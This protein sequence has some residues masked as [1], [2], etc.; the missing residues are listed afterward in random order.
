MS[1]LSVDALRSTDKVDQ[2]LL[3]LALFW[4]FGF[5]SPFLVFVILGGVVLG[6]VVYGSVTLYYVLALW[7]SRRII[8][9]PRR[10]RWLVVTAI[11]SFGSSMPLA[12]AGPF[13]Y[14]PPILV[15]LTL[16]FL[17]S[18]GLRMNAAKWAAIALSFTPTLVLVS[19]RRPGAALLAVFVAPLAAI[20]VVIIGHY[21]RSSEHNG[22]VER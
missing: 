21:V 18:N 6:V 19:T 22:F 8:S 9:S 11:A 5:T 7:L 3:A 2:V 15:P 20:I 10:T 14:A 4:G 16:A 12:T 17:P 13:F 1:R